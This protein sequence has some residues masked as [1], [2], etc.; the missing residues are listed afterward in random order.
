MKQRLA[1]QYLCQ[2]SIHD[3][4]GTAEELQ[5]RDVVWLYTPVLNKEIQRSFLLSGRVHTQLLIRRAL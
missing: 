2:K 4:G 3:K 5:I 1:Q